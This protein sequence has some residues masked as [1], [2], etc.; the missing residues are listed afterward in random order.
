VC[1]AACNGDDDGAPTQPLC[2]ATD[3]ASALFEARSGDTVMLGTCT[4]EADL[5]VPGGVSLVGSG[6]DRT[7]IVGLVA[8]IAVDVV[9][10]D[11]APTTVADLTIEAR[12]VVG[13]RSDGPGRIAI[14]RVRVEAFAGL[15]LGV[16]GANEV[17]LRE[18]DLVGPIT[19]DNAGDALFIQVTPTTEDP[20]AGPCDGVE[21]C[22]P[23]ELQ[24]VVCPSCG[25]VQQVCNECGDWVTVAATYGLALEA[26]EV[27]TLESVNLRGF[28][29]FAAV[30]RDHGAEGPIVPGVHSWTGGSISQNL[31]VGLYATGDVTLD[32]DGVEIT[33]TLRGLR[34]VPSTGAVVVEGV[35]LTSTSLVLSDN[36]DYGV[37]QSE[38]TASHTGLE[39]SN[40]GNAALWVGA[41]DGFVVDGGTISGNR[42]S[43][44]V[45]VDSSGVDLR[46]LVVSDTR[47]HSQNVGLWGA[48]RIGDGIQLTRTT[49]RV[50]LAH[51]ELT[52]N[53]RVG[54]LVDLGALETSPIELDDVTVDA[55][56]QESCEFGACF[57]AIAG[58]T[59]PDT[60]AFT[61]GGPAGWDEGI[62][63][64]GAAID[65]DPLAAGAIDYVGSVTPEELPVV[66]IV[67][68]CE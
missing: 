2:D 49:E 30:L 15:A 4:I 48:V 23:G 36:D 37:V 29:S 57:G 10:G 22:E 33:E 25:D 59:D 24:T 3:V 62:T 54:L 35:T 20:P 56:D 63:R 9:P 11:E 58:T 18:V 28:A 61:P 39:A 52:G 32:L 41:S 68:P 46:N 13:L 1:L 19:T 14:E 27:A 12:G 26:V 5:V 45:A 55:L 6:V 7:R 43:G 38:S 40:N 44:I 17:V 42:F 64:E 8:G 51:V 34:P 47:S 31:G 21:V 16:L 65:N 53:E 67:T 50:S 60:R 66:G